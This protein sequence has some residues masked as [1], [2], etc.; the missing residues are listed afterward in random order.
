MS[1]ATAGLYATLTAFVHPGD[2]VVLFEPCYDSYVPVIRLSGG[3]PVFVSL[4]YPDYRVDW[5]EVKRA[6][7]PRTR[8]ILVNTP[9]NPTGTAWTADDIRQL[10]SIVDGTDI[11]LIGDE[12][13]EHVIFDGRSTRAC[14][15]IP[16]CGRGRASSARLARPTT[17]PDGR[18]ATASR[19]SPS[20]PRCSACTSS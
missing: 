7:T 9:H 12:V 6:I 13:Y 16:T 10:T 3:T 1:G 15:A 11:L 8:A 20:W 19:R 14:C 18:S 4:R 2:E 5:D 17:P